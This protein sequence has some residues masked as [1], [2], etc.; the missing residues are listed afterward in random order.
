[1][2]SLF[3]SYESKDGTTW[4]VVGSDDIP[5]AAAVYVGI[6]VT[7]VDATKAIQAVVDNLSVTQSQTANKPPT[8]SLTAPAN[9]STFTAPANITLSAS[10]S[11]PDGSVSKVEFYSGSTLLSTDTTSSYSFAWSSVPAGTYSLTAVAYD[12]AGAKTTSA[13]VTVTVK[14]TTTTPPTAVVFQKSPD[15][16][17]LVTS[18]RLDVF[19]PSANPSTATPIATVNLG[20][21]TPDASGVITAPQSAFFLALAPG[22]YQATVTAIGSAGSSRSAAVTFTR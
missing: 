8:V 7:S 6:A 16:A 20:K 4:T 10:A 3:T 9:N 14:A 13:A 21:P 18:Y 2:G 12:A 5:M 11:D 1:V 17:T 15:H 19:A 22:T